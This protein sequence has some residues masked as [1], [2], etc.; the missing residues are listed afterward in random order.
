MED[1]EFFPEVT[2]VFERLSHNPEKITEEDFATLERF[3]VLLYD[4]SSTITDVNESRQWLFTKKSRSIEMVP[5]TKD[6]L[7]F[8]ML[9][10]AY[11]AG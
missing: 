4:R 6:A 5:P 3:T 1:M 11:Q 8:H 10:A 2:S 7:F 9:R